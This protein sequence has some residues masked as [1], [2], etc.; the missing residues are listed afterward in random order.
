[1]RAI[2]KH[3]VYCAAIQYIRDVLVAPLLIDHTHLASTSCLKCI[4]SSTDV[5]GLS[6]VYCRSVACVF[7][8]INVLV[9]GS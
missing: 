3:D 9:L 6:L 8:S 5:L 1:M 7:S 4:F 2:G